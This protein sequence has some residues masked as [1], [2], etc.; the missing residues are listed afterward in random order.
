MSR[1]RSQDS[2]P[3][4]ITLGEMRHP[5]GGRGGTRGL[6]VYCA[7]YRCGHMVRLR[8]DDVDRWPAEIRL[9]DLEPKFT[10]TRCGR[11]GADVRPDFDRPTM[12]TAD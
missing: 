9:S 5:E 6:L 11:R 10:C 4:K 2:V 8:P 12:G 1:R 7:D 3:Q